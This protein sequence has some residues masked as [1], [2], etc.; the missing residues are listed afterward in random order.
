MQILAA[1][2]KCSTSKGKVECECGV[3]WRKLVIMMI[4][5]MTND[6]FTLYRCINTVNVA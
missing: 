5:I 6:E 1:E 4:M 3:V 2:V